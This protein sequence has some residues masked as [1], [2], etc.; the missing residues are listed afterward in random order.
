M[1]KNHLSG[2]VKTDP[3][4]SFE[5]VL[6]FFLYPWLCSLQ[7]TKS[8]HLFLI[9]SDIILEILCSILCFNFLQIKHGWPITMYSN[10]RAFT[11]KKH[12]TCNVVT[13]RTC[14]VYTFVN[15]FTCGLG[16]F[17]PKASVVDTREGAFLPERWR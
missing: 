9:I 15:I 14:T 7:R 3:S 4:G 10:R 8:S 13:S 5:F 6:R 17:R 2:L 1:P 12:R 16:A 11:C